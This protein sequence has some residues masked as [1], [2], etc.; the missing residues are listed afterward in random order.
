M[1]LGFRARLFVILALFALVPSLVL[2]V[3]WGG[4]T[5]R[6]LPRMSGAAAW[7]SV[8]ASGSR[9]V[10]LALEAPASDEAKAALTRH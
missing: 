6:V 2:T 10:R 4:A 7:D 5:S 3:A 1:P 8:A 9:A